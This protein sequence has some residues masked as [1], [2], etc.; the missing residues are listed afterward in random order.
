MSPVDF[1]IIL[2]RPDAF[3]GQG[4]LV[5]EGVGVRL[6]RRDV[7]GA[8][9][10]EQGDQ[11]LDLFTPGFLLGLGCAPYCLWPRLIYCLYLVD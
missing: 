8:D 9:S 2:C 10:L 5:E 1:K 11:S 4:P 7:A 6:W 3:K